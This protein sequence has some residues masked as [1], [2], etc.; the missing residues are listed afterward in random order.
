MIVSQPR[1]ALW[2]WINARTGLKWSEDFRAIGAVRNDCL[3]AVVAYNA[4]TGRTCMMHSAIDDPSVINRTFVKAIFE[5][6]F[7]EVGLTHVLA[8]VEASNTR[9]LSIDSQCGFREINRFEGA[10]MDGSDLI[11]LQIRKH[12]CRWPN[13]RKI[14]SSSS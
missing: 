1:E 14:F 13:G 8:P 9:A 5:Y 6:P 4:F 10:S 12:E 11:L 2:A 7:V 3:L